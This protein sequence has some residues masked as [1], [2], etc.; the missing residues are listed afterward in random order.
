MK[1][2]ASSPKLYFKRLL[3]KGTS[4]EKSLVEFVQSAVYDRPTTIQANTDTFEKIF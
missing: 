3:H 1:L 2:Q 4:W